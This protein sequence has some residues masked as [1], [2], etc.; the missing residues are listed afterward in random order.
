MLR[1]RTA[2]TITII[3]PKATFIFIPQAAFIIGM[4][5]V[6]GVMAEICRRNMLFTRKAA[7]ICSFTRASHGLN[8][9]LHTF[10]R[11]MVAD[12]NIIDSCLRDGFAN[13]F[14]K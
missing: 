12:L 8:I 1:D 10:N 5:A 2:T 13:R 7:N 11:H 14:G 3:I 9:R 4:T 6:I